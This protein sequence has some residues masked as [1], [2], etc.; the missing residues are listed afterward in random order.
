LV[1][2]D[3]QT[4]FWEGTIVCASATKG[5]VSRMAVIHPKAR[6]P[7]LHPSRFILMMMLADHRG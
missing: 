1:D 5:S 4:P 6:F 2:P 3:G 7:I